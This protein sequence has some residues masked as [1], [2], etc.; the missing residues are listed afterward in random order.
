MRLAYPGVF[1][2]MAVE[3]AVTGVELGPITLA[4][5]SLMFAAKALKFWA[6][7]SLGT[8]WSYKVL[9]VPGL[10]LVDRRSVPVVPA[11]EL[12]RRRWRADR[13]GPDDCTRA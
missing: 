11:S 3:G 4:G 13:H 5:V 8:R 10:P 1:V 9:V 2:A 6:I 7:A 12:H